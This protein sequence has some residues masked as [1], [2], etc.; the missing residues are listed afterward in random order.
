[1]TK[2]V[3]TSAWP[4]SSDIPH[5]GNMIGSVLSADVFARFQRLI[6]NEV[7]FV[8]GSDEHGT[9]V[10]VEAI[11]RKIPIKQL[12]D[13]NHTRI[14]KIFNGWNMSYDNYTR[15]E[16]ETHKKFIRQIYTEIYENDSY[17]F[18]QV[19][20]IHYCS[21]DKRFLPDRFVEGTCPYCGF[22]SARGDQCDNCGRP[23]DAERLI[24]AYCVICKQPTELRET[25]QWFFDLPK[26][27]DYVSD[28]LSRA[29]LSTNVIKFCRGWIKDGLR[30]RSITRDSD[31]GIKAPF[32]GAEKK[33]IY[34]WME[35][36]LGYVSA[37][38]E[39]FEKKGTPERWKEFWLDPNAKTSFFIGKDNIPF[40][41]IILPSLLKASGKE[42]NEPNLISSTEFLN[43]ENQKFSKSRKIGIWT[44]EAL[45]LLPADYWRFSLV[46]LRPE[47]GD[48]NFGWDSFTEKVNNDL[49]DAIGNFV[50]RTLVGVSKFANNR[51]ELKLSDI[52]KEYS[53][54]VVQAK[55]RHAKV[56]ELYSKV[57]LQ[58]ACR[59][60]VVQAFEA[61]RFLSATEPWK[62]VKNDKSK[63]LQILYV[64]LSTLKLLSSELYPII[65]ETSLKIVKQSGVFKKT[66]GNPSW[67]DTSIDNDLPI[68]ASGIKPIFSKVN[69][70]ELRMK[71]DSLR[72][73][74]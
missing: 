20:R 34:V 39:Y 42:Y 29:E 67:E 50:N 16:S 61:N 17:I 46:A 53:D 33:T 6:G 74:K 56:H 25:T 23:L 48:V 32:P 30:P 43:F 58:S 1:M 11:K 35:A 4:Y 65:P 12:A 68:V 18:T 62:V 28:Y 49:N 69:A 8:S 44:D 63:A 31:W 64:S 21:N 7:V 19:E 24:K 66:N 45:E 70:E 40:H 57:E 27:S 9:P 37:V 51:F 26:L 2:W 55:D 5:L 59:S 36:V 54:L 47:A 52:P 38:I 22:E 41:A 14:C 3:V 60:I 10:E 13:E 72:A 71:L 15:T 73:S